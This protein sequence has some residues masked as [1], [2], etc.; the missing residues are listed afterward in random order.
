MN[1]GQH[2]SFRPKSAFMPLSGGGIGLFLYLAAF[3]TGSGIGLALGL[4]D[5]WRFLPAAV[6]MGFVAYRVATV[7]LGFNG[8]ELLIRNRYAVLW[9]LSKL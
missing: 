2:W 3:A 9:F 5:Y 7:R 4:H 8:R 1:R 6:S